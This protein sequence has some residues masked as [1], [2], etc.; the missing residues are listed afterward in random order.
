[1]FI[2]LLL[3]SFFLIINHYKQ[4]VNSN[5]V[6]Y[7]ELLAL[8]DKTTF[9][10]IQSCYQYTYQ[11]ISRA[12]FNKLEFEKYLYSLIDEDQKFF[13]NIITSVKTNKNKY[14]IYN[15]KAEAIKTQITVEM[16]KS[17]HIPYKLFIKFENALFTKT[18]LTKPICD[19]SVHCKIIYTTPAGRTTTWRENTFTYAQLVAEYEK[20]INSIRDKEIRKYHIQRERSMMSNGVRYDILKRDGFRCQICGSTAQDG[21]KLHVDHIIPISKGGHT[22]PDNLRTLCDRCNLGKSN[23]LE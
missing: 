6:R 17:L 15:K 20:V 18:L 8:N 11:C 1:M 4:L 22:T 2:A 3:I 12:E 13:K 16:C 10:A 7:K 19:V 14:A 5:S 9:H 23:K 21:V